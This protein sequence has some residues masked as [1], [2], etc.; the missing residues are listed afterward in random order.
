MKIAAM[1]N[2]N[3]HEAAGLLTK[4]RIPAVTAFRLKKI[5]DKINRELSNYNDVLT[6]MQEKHRR[7]DGEV[8]QT[9]FM[10]DYQDLVN[11]DVPMDKIPF[12]H[13]EN[14]NM[15]VEDLVALEPIIEGLETEDSIS[16]KA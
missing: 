9:A 7:A 6:K 13:L 15:S 16:E 5:I 1:L 2:A 8:D 11:I 14:A 4:A 10:K 3:M 12:A